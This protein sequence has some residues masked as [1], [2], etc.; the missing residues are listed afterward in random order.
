[1]NLNPSLLTQMVQMALAED[2]GRRGD[3]TTEATV[4]AET[5]AHAQMVAREAGV[6]AGMALAR[7]AFLALDPTLEV[8]CLVQDGDVV[9]ASQP[10]LTVA[11]RA[12]GILTAER[13]ALNFVGHLSG[14]AT[15]TAAF[16]EAIK[17]HPTQIVCTRKTI[18]GLRALQ[19]YAVRCGGGFNHRF[20]LDDAILIKDNHIA[21]AGGIQRALLAAKSVAGH[22]VKIEIEV[23]T[24]AQLEEALREGVDIILLD[25][26]SLEELQKAVQIN[27]GRALLE[28]SGNMSLE[29]VNVVAAT[30]VNVISVG[31]LTHSVKNLDIGLDITL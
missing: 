15:L 19:K 24:L 26:M 30:G 11:G 31:A 20:G 21:I 4:R 12:S 13:V 23:D 22:L 28:A 27:A 25:N 2:L 18:P 8:R 16:V 17:P 7:E 29:R 6:V 3:L 5:T 9:R 10:M 14:V 1:M